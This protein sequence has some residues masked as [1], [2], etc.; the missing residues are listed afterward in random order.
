MAP[1]TVMKK[2]LSNSFENGYRIIKT[3]YNGKD[4]NRDAT[5]YITHK[6]NDQNY[7]ITKFVDYKNSEESLIRNTYTFKKIQ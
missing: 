3:M 1:I 6:F 4:D 7:T 5:I 2:W